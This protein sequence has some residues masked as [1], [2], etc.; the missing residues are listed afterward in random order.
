MKAHEFCE[1]AASLVNGDRNETHGEAGQNHR[2][3]AALWSAYWQGRKRSG[4]NCDN[5]SAQDVA[6][7]MCLLKI[8]RTMTGRHNAD[9]HLDAIGYAAIAGQLAQADAAIAGKIVAAES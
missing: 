5:F 8:A 3:I 9:D 2:N 4:W 6:H 7:M 1:K